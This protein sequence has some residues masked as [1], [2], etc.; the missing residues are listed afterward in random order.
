MSDPC[1]VEWGGAC[2]RSQC[3][4]QGEQNRPDDGR[5]GSEGN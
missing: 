4:G 3:M 5:T 1:I 2:E